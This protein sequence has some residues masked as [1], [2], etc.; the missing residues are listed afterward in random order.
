M[1]RV[2][3]ARQREARASA[4]PRPVFDG[5]LPI[6]QAQDT[7]LEALHRH[8]VVIVCG[9]TGSGKTTQIPKF[10]LTLGRGIHGLIGCTQPRRIAARSVAMRLA[11]ELHTSVGAAV[12][13][14]VRFHDRVSDQTYIKVMTDGIL[15]SEIHHDRL[16]RRYDTLVVDEAHERSLNIDFLLGY[17]KSLLPR[18]P[19]L[20]LVITSATLESDR[21]SR[22]FNGAPVIEVSGR[23]YPVEVR[24][25]PVAAPDAGTELPEDREM[26]TA[27]LDAVD[28]ITR[29]PGD[30]DILVFL[31]GE[32]DIRDTA[33]ALRK[34][35]PPHTEILPLYARQSFAEQERVF[36]PTGGRRIVLSTNVAETSL[37]VPGIRYVVDTGLAR[38]SRY[39][40]RSK[41]SQ[42]QV[43]KISQASARQRAGRCGRVSA[44]ICIRLYD[45]QDF[46]ARPP[47]TTPEILR[48]SLAAVILKMTALGLGQVEDFPFLDPPSP[49]A[50]EDGYQLL[51][52][53]G[54]FDAQRKLTAIGQQLAR[55][56]VD[57][58]IGRMLLAA[59]QQDCLREMLVIAAA[60]S[61][62]DPR[63]R[64]HE[65]QQAAEQKHA[66]F[67]HEHSEFLSYLALWAFVE[68][69]LQ[70]RK[71]GRKL[72]AFFREEFL[73]LRRI[74]EWRDIHSQLHALVAEMG[75]RPNT[76]PA[77]YDRL[78]Q[79]LLAGLLGHIGQRDPESD[80]YL[81]A[82]G[83]RFR[84]L[85]SALPPKSK[86]KWVMAAELT[87][88]SQL[89]ARC[90]A[91]IEPEWIEPIAGP[92]VRRSHFDPFWDQA[93]A[94][95]N[96][97]EKVTLYGLPIVPKRRVR[98]GPIDPVEA[99][100]LFIHHALVLGEFKTTAPFLAHNQALVAAVEDLEH[101][102]RRQDVLVNEA[103]LAG[104]YD[105]LLPAAVWSGQ[106]FETWRREAERQ[107]PRLL[108]LERAQLMRHEARH[109]TEALFPDHLMSGETILPLT[110]RFDP[111]HP[112]DGVT[113]SLPLVLL[114]TLD[115]NRLSWLVP[116]LIREKITALVKKLPQRLRRELVPLPAFITAFLERHDAGSGALT[117]CLGDFIHARTGVRV[118]E[119][120]WDPL[121]DH[122]HFNIR[123]LDGDGQE[124]ASSRNLAQLREA[125][126]TRA[127]SALQAPRGNDLARSGLT[128]WDF[129]DFPETV[130]LQRAGAQ[131]TVHPALVDEGQSVALQLMAQPEQALRA[132]RGGVRRLMLLQW[133]PSLKARGR[134][135]AGLS[136]LSL[137]YA[138]LPGP[139]TTATATE[140]L[141]QEIYERA[142]DELL[143]PAANSLRTQSAY[144]ALEEQVRPQLSSRIHEVATLMGTVLTLYQDLR[145]TLDKLP[146]SRVPAGQA[147]IRKHLDFLLQKNTF[148]Q[149]ALARLKHFPRYLKAVQMRLQ[150]LPQ[151]PAGDA[152]KNALLEQFAAAWHE[153]V[154]T[155]GMSEGLEAFR[156]MMEE[157]H[158]SLF[159]QTLKT[160]MPVSVQRLQKQWAAL[161][162][163]A[164]GNGGRR[165]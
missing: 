79:A 33:E 37:T 13:Y 113:L 130:T 62:Q 70:H 148:R 78:H 36:R 65:H 6:H 85:P 155:Q 60:L 17:L 27:L 21:L 136:Q 87:E 41:V 18:R 77:P 14:Q 117:G 152:E 101:K 131:L 25:R 100:R 150:K 51:N 157:L 118:E 160:P 50:I 132:T 158:V 71:S 99:R 31:S 20:K 137:Q 86:P 107:H 76:I 42:L 103:A 114:E 3:D 16:L 106:R 4:L 141:L 34:H 125:W 97:H 133:A 149:N 119:A 55:L 112:L 23:T 162:H 89:F 66:R 24:W 165:L 72:A 116:G 52:E 30:G 96:I 47:Y 98:Y 142:L 143:P 134:A 1:A 91:R 38:V 88:T 161:T 104:F 156:W 93:S 68:E 26:R 135:I 81:G 138:L 59:Q 75:L 10:C 63:D 151:D 108:F 147:G 5:S 39:S 123:L 32:R 69:S 95:A 154:R 53:L 115:A 159:A 83:L 153:R 145:N 80:Q 102:S 12:G 105:G 127:R 8:Q 109:V 54:A 122:L 164:A 120:Q 49:R 144:E 139:G 28:E 82:R 110:Y 90:I 15:L 11:E 67:R 128:R 124:V 94:Q 74:R 29:E 44:G 35:H 121:P 61:G 57:P 84:I 43:E 40:L 146:Q 163:Q 126:G 56:P 64:P 129:G 22:H 19:D 48:T 9:E 46:A 45:E 92:L 2:F 73:S 111:G 58:R 7:L 140:A